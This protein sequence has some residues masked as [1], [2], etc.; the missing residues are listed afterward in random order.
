MTA[1]DYEEVSSILLYIG[2]FDGKFNSSNAVRVEVMVN[3]LDDN[4]LEFETDYYE[5]TVDE[6]RTPGDFKLP[7]IATD[8]DIPMLDV[9]YTI[10]PV[11]GVEVPFQIIKY[12][13]MVGML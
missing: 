12:M 7:I 8:K 11:D 1:L 4:I 3:N 9:L 13:K 5:S 2:S 10:V 6:N